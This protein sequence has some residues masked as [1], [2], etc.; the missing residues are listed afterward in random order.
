M[1]DHLKKVS[2][3]QP[4]PEFIPTFRRLNNVRALRDR[5]LRIHQELNGK[6]WHLGHEAAPLIGSHTTALA[7]KRFEIDLFSLL[8]T[9][10]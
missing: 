6:A 5:K 8:S 10:T 4:P 1:I 2:P 7:Q 3:R 9:A